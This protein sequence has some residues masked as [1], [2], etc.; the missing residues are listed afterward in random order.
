[1]NHQR[2]ILP[3]AAKRRRLPALI[4]V[5]AAT[6]A[7]LGVTNAVAGPPGPKDPRPPPGATMKGGLRDMF[8]G[9]KADGKH[10]PDGKAGPDGE[11]HG[12]GHG[13]P[14][15]TAGAPGLGGPHHGGMPP[16]LQKKL[17]ELKQ[18]EAAGKLTDDE[19][20]EL[21]RLN[22]FQQRRL[23]RDERRARLAALKQKETDGKLTP[24]EKA[25]LEKVQ[26]VHE[27][28]EDLAKKAK[29]RAD[30]RKQRS[31][32]AKR[33]ALKESPKVRSDAA[34]TAEYRKHAERLAKLERA[35]ELA[36]ADQNTDAA[37]KIDKLI[38]QETQRHQAWLA[39]QTAANAASQGA[40]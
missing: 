28:Y 1:M 15:G 16:G 5:A 6:L 8:G 38:A 35:K 40:K 32:E 23:T 27:R 2:S 39:K 17:D 14:Q 34:T 21:A 11:R 24:D 18:K 30:S 37:T 7:L 10:G 9:G 4:A 29:E 22:Q 13:G 19:K 33:Q 31:R 20:K 36:T 26:K 12:P 25:E 3:L